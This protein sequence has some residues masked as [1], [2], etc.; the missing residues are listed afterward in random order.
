[1]DKIIVIYGPTTSNKLGLAL[2]LSKYIWGKYQ[3][4]S[5]VIN[6]DSRKIYKGFT[7]SQSLPSKS[8]LQKA[9]VHLFG[10]VSPKEK[11]DLFDFQKL[12]KD[13]VAE[14]Q[15]R[16][17][18]SI[19]VGGSSLHLLSVLQNWRK[20]KRKPKKKLPLE[21]EPK[22][23]AKVKKWMLKDILDYAYH[24][25]LGYKKFLG[26]HFVKDFKEARRIADLFLG[27]QEN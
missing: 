14:V 24:Q 11:L 10:V 17:N 5:E 3:I 25:T 21:L 26:I 13:K 22:N 12:V 15:Q 20:G 16:G 19:L 7:I 18:L 1:M 27:Y 6:T 9:R 4:E 23:L 8:F 2:N